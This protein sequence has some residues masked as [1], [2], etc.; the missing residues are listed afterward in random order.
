MTMSAYGKSVV[1]IVVMLI[2]AVAGTATTA[3]APQDMAKLSAGNNEFATDLYGKL[4]S[5]EG[6]LFYSPYSISTALAM[7]YMGARSET[8]KQMART[9]HFGLGQEMLHPAMADLQA[10]LG[11]K[12]HQAK[13]YELNV[14]NAVWVQEG[15]KLM[16][17]FTKWMGA[18]YT[19]G[20]D[21]VDF[22]KPQE[23]TAKINGWVERQTKDKI[24]EL[25]SPMMI[26]K[27][28][29][30]VLVNAIYFKGL[31]EKP[32]D[33]KLTADGDF[34]VS[35][36]K[37]VRVPMMH[38]TGK[39]TLR[40]AHNMQLLSMPYKGGDLAMVV[41]LPKERDGLADLEKMLSP[42]NLETW[43]GY[44]QTTEV[45]VAVP[46]FKMA[47]SFELS[48]TLS[49]MGMVDAFTA[50]ADFSGMEEKRELFI[51]HVVHKAF[52]EVN[53]E[54]TEAAAATGVVMTRAIHSEPVKFTADHPFVFAIRDNKTGSILFMG[55]VVNPL[56]GGDVK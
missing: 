9:M 7:T 16:P 34:H 5:K 54:G 44:L 42:N 6:N 19:G 36:D 55:R 46:R 4:R 29:G 43:L 17:E 45:E 14:A 37:A 31:W 35:V 32:F 40:D 27:D 50:K 13:A 41:L 20:L 25:F 49:D 18:Y 56:E 51:S 10:R 22:Q 12:E 3:P 11:S 26:T 38:M 24:R 21:K 2:V 39:F 47:K 48:K 53:E 23:A 30:C 28:T 33:K 15:Y 1:A 52:V 8:E